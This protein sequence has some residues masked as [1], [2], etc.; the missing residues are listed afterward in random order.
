M[1]TPVFSFHGN[2]ILN[3]FL[4]LIPVTKAL[5]THSIAKKNQE[6]FSKTEVSMNCK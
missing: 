2:M 1:V 3:Q 6:K 4:K 5:N